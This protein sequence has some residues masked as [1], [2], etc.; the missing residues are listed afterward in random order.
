MV[1]LF[2][3]TVNYDSGAF[4]GVIGDRRESFVAGSIKYK[5]L[6]DNLINDQTT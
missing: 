1:G 5:L 4:F 3:D 6:N 2:F